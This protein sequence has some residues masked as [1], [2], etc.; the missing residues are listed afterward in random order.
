MGHSAG[1]STNVALL[2]TEQGS[3]VLYRHGDAVPLSTARRT[4]FGLGAGG[5]RVRGAKQSR[6]HMYDGVS[7]LVAD[8]TGDETGG[9]LPLRDWIWARSLAR[10]QEGCASV[11]GRQSHCCTGNAARQPFV[12]Y[13]SVWYGSVWRLLGRTAGCVAVLTR[14]CDRFHTYSRA[15]PRRRFPVGCF[16]CC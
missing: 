8:V 4:N 6:A 15:K 13:G 7:W 10:P 3:L 9:V 11:R 12:R 1:G 2:R 16:P 14:P 5:V